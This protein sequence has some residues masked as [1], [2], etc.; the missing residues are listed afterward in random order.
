MF[1]HDIKDIKGGRVLAGD[2][3]PEPGY[4]FVES[5]GEFNIYKGYEQRKDFYRAYKNKK[6]EYGNPSLEGIKRQI[7]TKD[8]KTKDA[9]PTSQA[10][11]I[12][13]SCVEI[14]G[15]EP[16]AAEIQSIW[17]VV[18]GAGSGFWLVLRKYLLDNRAL[19]TT[20]DEKIEEL[21]KGKEKAKAIGYGTDAYDAAI[22]ILTNDPLKEGSS[23]ETIGENIKTEIEAGKPQKQAVAI[24]MSKAGKSKDTG[25]DVG[26][27]V[28]IIEGENRGKQGRLIKYSDDDRFVFINV[29]SQTL[30]VPVDYVDYWPKKRDPENNY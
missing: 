13:A 9:V 18:E 10:G 23:K 6:F 16:S 24:A 15:R 29:G 3:E 28:K 19:A 14:W 7:D 30:K 11:L 5:Y 2:G 1:V 27:F 25:G 22:D 12:K 26:A 4:S 21:E 20:N 17:N 8:S